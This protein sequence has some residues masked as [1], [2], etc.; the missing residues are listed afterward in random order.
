MRVSRHRPILT[1]I[2]MAGPQTRVQLSKEFDITLSGA[3]RLIDDLLAQRIIAA[4]GEVIESG[5]RPSYLFDFNPKL[6]IL[7]TLEIGREIS[8]IAI[9]DFAGKLMRIQKII[10]DYQL[11]PGEFIIKLAVTLKSWMEN[12]PRK[13]LLALTMVCDGIVNEHEKS[14]SFLN[15]N[16]AWLRFRINNSLD[17]GQTKFT[18]IP[19]SVAALAAESNMGVLSASTATALF[20]YMDFCTCCA[21]INRGDIY[22]S[23]FNI[24]GQIAHTPWE[25]NHRQC[26]CGR[27]GCAETLVCTQFIIDRFN[28]ELASGAENRIGNV[29]LTNIIRGASQSEKLCLKILEESANVAG[30]LLAC[31][32]NLL[33]PKHLILGGEIFYENPAVASHLTRIISN[34]VREKTCLQDSEYLEISASNLAG[35]SLLTGGAVLARNKWIQEYF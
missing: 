4:T 1:R 19:K 32:V 10:T 34:A 29:N 26:Y 22:Q 35:D 30:T 24:Y 23:P 2:S 3:K 33:G 15:Q 8:R 28:E 7:G 20:F 17:M 31:P 5:R 14:V 9:F 6:G 25:K 11:D 12:Y 27:K 18:L 13:P 21:F 16:R